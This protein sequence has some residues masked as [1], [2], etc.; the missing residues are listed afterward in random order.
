MNKLSYLLN[1]IRLLEYDLYKNNSPD[2][3]KE[4]I[5]L[6]LEMYITA[7]KELTEKF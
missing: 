7:K 4:E 1:D 6:R 5:K 3:N 2:I